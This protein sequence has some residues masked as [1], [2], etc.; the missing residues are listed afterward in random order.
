M[1]Q[2]A[3]NELPELA[4][5]GAGLPKPELLIAR[6]IFR[7]GLWRSDRGRSSS[8]FAE[9]RD[10]IQRLAQGCDPVAATRRV[11]V[12]RLPGMEDSS[13]NW[14]FC[15]TLD[16]LRIVNDAVGG[17][18]AALV[19]GHVP[20]HAASTAAVKPLADAGITAI[21]AFEASCR[22]FE[23]L[24]AATPELRTRAKYSHP[25]FGPLDAAGWHFM[26]GFHMEL[27]RRQLE[28]ILAGL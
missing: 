20:I 12:R 9:Q 5:P 25:W 11:L 13:R 18:I 14:S 15:M 7:W 22:Q 27:H 19:A 24:V 21:P 17:A 1:T 2:V 26:A 6:L 10:A 4:P 28:L 3:A 8:R 23:Q 16:H